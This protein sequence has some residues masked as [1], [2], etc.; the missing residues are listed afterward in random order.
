MAMRSRLR[1]IE[2]GCRSNSTGGNRLGTAAGAF[3]M[4]DCGRLPQ[5]QAN[6]VR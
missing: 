5:S 1:A 2:I 4:E 3:R 6:F